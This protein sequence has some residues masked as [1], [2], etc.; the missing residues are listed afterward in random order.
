MP[1]DLPAGLILRGKRFIIYNAVRRAGKNGIDARRL[2][3]ILYDNDPNG[4]PISPKII[5]AHVGQI[6]HRLRKFDQRLISGQTGNGVA[7]IYR[8]IRNA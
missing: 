1:P 3:S 8:L 2:W 4:G 6:N 7:G 5:S